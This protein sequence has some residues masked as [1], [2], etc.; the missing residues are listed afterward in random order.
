MIV[1]NRKIVLIVINVRVIALLDRIK[2]QAKQGVNR[3]SR[4]HDHDKCEVN[5]L[6][7]IRKVERLSP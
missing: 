6:S 5:D 3:L 1:T 7:P 4:Y 2:R